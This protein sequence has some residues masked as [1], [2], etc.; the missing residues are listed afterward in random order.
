[1]DNKSFDLQL[2]VCQKGARGPFPKKE[3]VK[4]KKSQ[5]LRGHKRA[6][7]YNQHCRSEILQVRIEGSEGKE[8]NGA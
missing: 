5:Q 1:L 7:Q 6:S 3:K 8:K 4:K 2:A